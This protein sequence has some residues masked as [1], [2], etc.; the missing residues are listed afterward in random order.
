MQ[1]TYSDFFGGLARDFRIVA[2]LGIVLIC[3]G[4]CFAVPNEPIHHIELSE[5]MLCQ[6]WDEDTPIILPDVVSPEETKIC[7]CGRLQFRPSQIDS[8]VLYLQVIWYGEEGDLSKRLSRF[9][10]GR[11]R[12]CV[13]RSEGFDPGDYAV[14]VI[15]GKKTLAHL[16]FTVNE[17]GGKQQ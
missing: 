4:C 3:W 17:G 1:Q 9:R 11:F 12:S 13:I 5:P 10:E 7:L 14:V 8:R 2:I 16:K 6:G 15:G